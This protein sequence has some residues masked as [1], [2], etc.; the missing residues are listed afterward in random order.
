M[1]FLGSDPSS[2]FVLPTIIFHF[3]SSFFFPPVFTWRCVSQDMYTG[4]QT[5]STGKKS[6][7]LCR[8]TKKEN[9]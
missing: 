5:A 7:S 1:A 2:L 3:F 4:V 8:A 9:L 6:I